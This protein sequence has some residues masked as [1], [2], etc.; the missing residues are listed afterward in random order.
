MATLIHHYYFST[1][2]ISNYGDKDLFYRIETDN[3]KSTINSAFCQARL[4]SFNFQNTILENSKKWNLTISSISKI[5]QSV[6]WSIN[7]K[8][9]SKSLAL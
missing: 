7:Y 1:E 6:R 4:T 3:T 9:V 8:W 5:I 2:I